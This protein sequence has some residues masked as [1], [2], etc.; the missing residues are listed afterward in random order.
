MS[1]NVSSLFKGERTLL[2][3]ERMPLVRSAPLGIGANTPAPSFF[4]LVPGPPAS[5]V[6]HLCG[7]VH[8][9]RPLMI[10]AIKGA[11]GSVELYPL[12]GQEPGGHG[13]LSRDS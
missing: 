11:A 6:S 5:S 8:E 7:G 10:L 3:F 13:R 2:K 9:Q 4:G 1:P 12:I